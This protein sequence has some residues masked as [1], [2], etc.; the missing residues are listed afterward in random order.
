MDILRLK[1]VTEKRAKDFYKMGIADSAS[2]VRH[3]PRAYLDMTNRT[4]VREVFHNDMALLA[5][6]LV[7]AEPVRH[8]SRLKTV[9]AW[10]EQDG[11]TFP[12]VW[13]NMPYLAERLK[14]GEYL[15]YG[16]V[17]NRYGQISLV[18][19]SFEPLDR[20][21]R[22][23]GIVP[24]YPLRGSL[25]QRVVRDAVS[26]ALAAEPLET[27]IPW[28]LVKKYALSPLKEAYYAV[29]APKS[30]EEARAGAE[31]IA[32]EEYFTLLSAFKLVKGDRQEARR[33][34]YT[35]TERDVTV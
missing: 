17:Q 22:L 8:Y 11:V 14:P 34:R 19:P 18:N 20:V 4:S 1:G 33:N 35:V 25:T 31:R 10:L 5:C 26:A 29:H 23:K 21:A 12:A 30:Q 32:L 28:E 7:S 9:R 27:V 24:V 3:F 2:L 15:F 13:F 6:R 16:R